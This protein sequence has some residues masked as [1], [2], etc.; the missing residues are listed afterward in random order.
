M[1]S[2]KHRIYGFDDLLAVCVWRTNFKEKPCRNNE[3]YNSGHG[4]FEVMDK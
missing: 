2:V 1:T 4:R 3:I